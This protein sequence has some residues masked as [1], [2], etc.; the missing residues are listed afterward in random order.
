[1][2]A[3]PRDRVAH[4]LEGLRSDAARS[5]WSSILRR[6][7]RDF[8]E[9]ALLVYASA[10]AFRILL[11]LVPLALFGVALLGFLQLD[12][13][14][15]ES[16]APEIRDRVSAPAFTLIDRTAE[17]VL[18]KKEGWWLTVGAA[19]ALWE[20]SAGIRIA[21]R[22]LDRIYEDRRS[23]SPVAR[24][25]VS[26]ALSV[27]I[28]TLL[29]ASVAAAQILPPALD[30]RGG[31]AVG[32]VVAR[33]LGWG[34]SAI[35]ISAAIAVL[36]RFGSSTEKPL[37]VAGAASVVVVA[38][39]TVASTLFG[40]Y[41]TH[42]ASYGTLLGGLAFVFVLM[43]YVYIS[44]VTFLA[45]LQAAAHVGEGARRATRSSGPEHRRQDPA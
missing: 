26:L 22:A 18:T 35:L 9:K 11:A 2:T 4:G 12:E 16:V 21:M 7:A 19:V 5:G 8:A 20:V 41:A 32:D 15:S 44:A 23:R 1:M 37:H 28:S 13:V 34:L 40:L 33:A 25:A 17:Q 45:G 43:V 3:S 30:R 38:C 31:S 29:L 6:F 10:L 24:L 14:W 42:V 27:P 39:W 36:V